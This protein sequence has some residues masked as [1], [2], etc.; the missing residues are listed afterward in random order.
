MKE[1][2]IIRTLE[3]RRRAKEAR[4]R[5]EHADALYAEIMR[6]AEEGLTRRRKD[7]KEPK[8]FEP[9]M[10]ADEPAFAQAMAGR[11]G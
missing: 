7:A 8:K 2:R 4:E 5:A 1:A 11:R 10:N 3:L 9:R 6:L